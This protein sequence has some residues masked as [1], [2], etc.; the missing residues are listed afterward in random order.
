[1][2]LITGTVHKLRVARE[3][4][5]YGYFLTDGESDVLMHYSEIVGKK[6]KLNAELDVYLFHDTEDRLSC[7]MKTPLIMLGELK[8]LA[9]ADVHPRLGCFSGD[10]AWTTA[11]AA[12]IRAAGKN[13]IPSAAWR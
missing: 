8:R 3:V 2:S 1:M 13:R 4:P 11:V 5:P 9:V 10:G 7:T 12:F 6:P